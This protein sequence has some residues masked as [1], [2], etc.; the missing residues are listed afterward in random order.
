VLQEEKSPTCLMA[1]SIMNQHHHHSS[2]NNYNQQRHYSTSNNNN[3]PQSQYKSYGG[4]ANGSGGGPTSTSNGYHQKG[5]THSASMNE[6]TD[7]SRYQPSQK[8]ANSSTSSY[9]KNHQ[10]EGVTHAYQNQ[11]YSNNSNSFYQ[12][13]VGSECGANTLSETRK[14][15]RERREREFVPS[16]LLI[17]ACKTNNERKVKEICKK[18][19]TLSTDDVQPVANFQDQAGRV[20]HSYI[21]TAL[22]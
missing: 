13:Q 19:S 18:L 9:Q 2:Y 5:Y 4:N 10:Y 7:N 1:S 17:D 3:M 6:I 22:P 20:S 16:F 12:S 21:I 11:T 14:E 8:T 15:Q